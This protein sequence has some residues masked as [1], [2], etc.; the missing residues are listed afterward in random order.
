MPLTPNWNLIQV[1][2]TYVDMSG[3]PMSGTVTFTP[4]VSVTIAEDSVYKQLIVPLTISATLDGSGHF[5]VNLP[6]S[7]DPDITPRGWTYNVVE[8]MG[9]FTR[10][11]AIT[12][13]VSTVGPL[14]LSTVAPAVSSSGMTSYTLLTTTNALTTRVSNLE[15][16]PASPDYARRFAMLFAGM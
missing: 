7:D 15:A 1:V 4:D 11:Y 13:P 16:A 5:S 6:A 3:N 9:S 8:T 14:D 12:V 2:G 10:K